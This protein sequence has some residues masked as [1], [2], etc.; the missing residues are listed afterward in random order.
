MY[1]C[2]C[3]LCAI[4]S[5]FN[6]DSSFTLICLIWNG[7]FIRSYSS[8][9]HSDTLHSPP[10]PSLIPSSRAYSTSLVSPIVMMF[11][12]HIQLHNIDSPLRWIPVNVILEPVWHRTVQFPLLIF[13]PLLFSVSPP[14]FMCSSMVDCDCYILPS[15][16]VRRH[17]WVSWLSLTELALLTCLPLIFLLRYSRVQCRLF[18]H[19]Y[20]QI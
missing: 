9:W 13:I 11:A 20:L 16:D 4:I 3:A 7:L 5:I 18:T 14:P 8:W 12:L 19:T 2:V 1:K 10:P 6:S 15:R 17:E